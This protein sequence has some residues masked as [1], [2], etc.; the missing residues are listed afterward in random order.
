MP[1]SQE[2]A[3]QIREEVAQSRK[4]LAD[5]SKEIRDHANSIR[6]IGNRMNQIYNRLQQLEEIEGVTAQEFNDIA[7]Q[8]AALNTT[9]TNL[10]ASN[11]G[12]SPNR[13]G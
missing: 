2:E 6:A 13:N 9:I 10:Q 7:S 11:N 4:D 1:I 12:R 3:R 8:V 5:A